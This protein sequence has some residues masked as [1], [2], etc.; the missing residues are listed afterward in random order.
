MIS[1]SLRTNRISVL[2][3]NSTSV[4]KHYSNRLDKIIASSYNNNN[5]NVVVS[6][7]LNKNKSSFTL[8]KNSIRNL[9]ESI[10]LLFLLSKKR[11]VIINK[12][13]KIYNYKASFITLTLPAK[14][15]HTDVK[16]KEHFSLFLNN[17]RNTLKVNNYV[18]K[19][20]LQK[21][22]NLHFHLV[23][24]KYINY[25]VLLY[26]WN[27]QLKRLGYVTLYS[28]KFS[29]MTLLDY[30]NYRGK[31][32][33][34]CSK[35]YAFGV[36]SKWQSP[37]TVSVNSIYSSKM[38]ASYLSKYISKS[39]SN[40]NELTDDELIRASKI[41]KLWGRSHSISKF[42]KM[43][44]YDVRS[45]FAYIKKVKGSDKIKRVKNDFCTTFYLYFSS[46]NSEFYKW[47]RS[48]FIDV[49]IS[50]NYK[51]PIPES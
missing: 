48:V 40:N 10:N 9:T 1:A 20:E 30:A 22:G 14:Q 11:V 41:G 45:L 51:F 36:K 49:A 43:S 29:K 33:E 39:S 17:I 2:H 31:K 28:N 16:L 25:N 18:W 26:Y 47:Y 6:E 5:N 23:I 38:L 34:E 7:N 12:K 13:K 46:L 42:P 24:D 8:S 4:Y 32:V 35:A 3:S 21:N 50:S 37:N 27:L 19:C 15:F 44:N